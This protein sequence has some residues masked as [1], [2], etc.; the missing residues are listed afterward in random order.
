[1]AASSLLSS[2]ASSFHGHCPLFS[3]RFPAPGACGNP[4]NVAPLAVRVKAAAGDSIVLVEK[5]EAEK[6]NRLKSNYIEKIV[7][8]LMDEFSYTNIHQVVTEYFRNL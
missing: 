6:V 2:A 4:S 8:L 1:M 5:A 3:V 7:P